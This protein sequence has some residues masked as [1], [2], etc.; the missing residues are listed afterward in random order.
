MLANKVPAKGRGVVYYRV[1]SWSGNNNFPFRYVRIWGRWDNCEDDKLMWSCD[2]RD[3]R[4]LAFLYLWAWLVQD[5]VKA[6][7]WRIFRRGR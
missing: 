7:W 5:I 1:E 4:K 3:F 6:T 2:E